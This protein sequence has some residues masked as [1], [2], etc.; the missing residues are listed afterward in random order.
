MGIIRISNKLSE[1]AQQ[2][3]YLDGKPFSLAGRDHLLKPYDHDKRKTLFLF[4][5]QAE[6]STTLASK[7]LTRS[8]VNSFF[9]TLYV[10]PR[11]QQVKQFVSQKLAPFCG[12][13][14]V[15][16]N[17]VNKG[18]ATGFFYRT[19]SNGSDYT[20][21]SAFLSAESSRGVSADA[22]Y[23]DEFQDIMR[24]HLPVIES[25]LQHAK[26]WAR[27]REY[28]GTPKSLQNH[29]EYEWRNSLKF[30][31]VI[32]CRGCN[33]HNVLGKSNI[34]RDFL[35]C[36]FC[37]KQIFPSDGQWAST[38]REGKFPAF[39]ICY[40]MVPW[41]MWRNPSDASEPGVIQMLEEWSEERFLNEVLA[42]SA[43]SS[44]IP[45]T[46]DQLKAACENRRIW[47]KIDDYD[48]L[49]KPTCGLRPMKMY[50]GIDW[51]TSEENKSATVFTIGAYFNDGVFRVLFMK[52]YKRGSYTYDE[53][54][55]DIANLIRKYRV[56][57]VGSDWG[58]GVPQNAYL[59][60]KFPNMIKAFYSSANSGA[61]IVYKP[62]VL[63]YTLSKPQSTARFLF[64]I[65]N[66]NVR[67]FNWQGGDSHLGF[68]EFGKEFLALRREYNIRQRTTSYFHQVGDPDDCFY[69]ANYCYCAAQI[70]LGNFIVKKGKEEE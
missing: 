2:L 40:L 3:F 60:L 33:K 23:I 8:L 61:Y 24:D 36:S 28:A 20:L 25:S 46:I 7:S 48:K 43:D 42:I 39:R 47:E 13:P 17:F 6:K 38:N 53:E 21:K 19:F 52:R 55:K 45:L 50:A 30:E 56:V 1:F 63:R 37:G 69:S 31:W 51:G 11:E 59:N 57:S 10:A 32:K 15:T 65:Q 70:D 34:G 27:Y 54:L 62:D 58:F 12:S 9:K 49:I 22:V 16:E 18:C 41:V 14:M 29:I 26:K 67:F 64:D 5:R 68:E 35:I 4:S 66:R 44:D